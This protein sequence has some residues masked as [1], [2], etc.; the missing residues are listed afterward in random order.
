M[1]EP[2]ANY[3]RI[4]FPGKLMIQTQEKG[5]KPHFG[6]DLGLLDP[7]SDRQNFF[8]KTSG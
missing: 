3:Y 2:V 6:S 4:Q 7:Y 1:L 5:N 8:H